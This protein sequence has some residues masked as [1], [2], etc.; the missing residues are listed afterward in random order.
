MNNK[1]LG[2]DIARASHRACAPSGPSQQAV[3]GEAASPS[4]KLRVL[5]L[6]AGIGGFDLGLERTGGFKTVAFCEID[7]FCRARLADHWPEVPCHDD[8]RTLEGSTFGPIDVVCGGFPCQDISIAGR[9][10]GITGTRSGL[11]FEMQRVVGEAKPL[12]VVIEN[13]P[14]L[15]AR[16]LEIIL[17]GLDALGYDAEWHCL[18]AAYVG[19]PHR[20]DRL[21]LLAYRKG[22]PFGPYA[23]CIRSHQAQMHVCGAAEFLN[24]QERDLGSLAWWGAPPEVPRVVDGVPTKLDIAQ[25]VATGNAVVPQIAELIGRAIL[26]ARASERLAA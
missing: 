22:D 23:D 7:P 26:A 17:R 4:R 6:F 5:S 1:D 11:W 12:Y 2:R 13:S 9:G 24:Q 14:R 16:G 10:A 18:P 25:I 3:S 8:I 21:C 20:R 15:R 19:A